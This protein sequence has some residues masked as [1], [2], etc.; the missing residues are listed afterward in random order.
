MSETLTE[1]LAREAMERAENF[2][3]SAKHLRD[4]GD[5]DLNAAE[6]ARCDQ[7]AVAAEETALRLMKLAAL[8]AQ[9]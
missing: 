4:L 6:I 5:D 1:K 8:E 9:G 7:Q 2:R 3:A